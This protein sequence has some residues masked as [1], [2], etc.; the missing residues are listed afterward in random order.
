MASSF[1]TTQG[2]PYDYDSLM[3]YGAYA[4]TRNGGPT[5]E[6]LNSGVSLD[7]LGQ[8]SGF[9]TYDLEHVNVLYCSEGKIVY[10][11]GPLYTVQM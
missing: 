4:F 1:S 3:H 5:I 2:V 10:A 9:S 6:P 7:A 11:P 8:R